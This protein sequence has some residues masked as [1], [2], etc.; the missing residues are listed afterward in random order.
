[1]PH[2]RVIGQLHDRLDQLLAAVV[3]RMRLQFVEDARRRLVAA[4]R[5]QNPGGIPPAWIG[6]VFDPTV[7]TIGF[8]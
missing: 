3:G 7:L 1:M 8:A 5:E 6:E 2:L 4:W